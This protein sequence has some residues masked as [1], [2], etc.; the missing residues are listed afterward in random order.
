M[1]I[2]RIVRNTRDIIYIIVKSLYYLI[3]PQNEEHADQV[4]PLAD[5]TLEIR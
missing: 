1:G 5:K 3:R 2:I 4:E